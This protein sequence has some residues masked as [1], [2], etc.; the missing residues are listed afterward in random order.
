MT[1]AWGHR[2]AVGGPLTADPNPD[3]PGGGSEQGR[4]CLPVGPPP[5][6][7]RKPLHPTR[8]L[9]TPGHDTATPLLCANPP[10]DHTYHLV[11]SLGHAG[12]SLYSLVTRAALEGSGPSRQ[13]CNSSQ[14]YRDWPAE[15]SYTGRP[16]WCMVTPGTM[17]YTPS[18]VEVPVTWTSSQHSEGWGKGHMPHTEGVG[19]GKGILKAMCRGGHH[20]TSWDEGGGGQRFCRREW[21]QAGEGTGGCHEG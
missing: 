19:V 5:A 11:A 14:K 10:S 17:A 1:T 7:L 15:V 21:G 18:D 13:H 20:A 12:D 16:F 6:N 3:R 9:P 4:A 2:S 8:A